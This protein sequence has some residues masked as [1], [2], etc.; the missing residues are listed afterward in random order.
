MQR[1]EVSGAVRLIY[2]S[3][4]VKWL[5][6]LIGV[7][8]VTRMQHFCEIDIQFNMCIAFYYCYSDQY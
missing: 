2:R 1:S 6:H 7:T 3:S 5:M 8:N 4:G